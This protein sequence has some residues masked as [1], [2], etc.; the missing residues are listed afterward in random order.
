MVTLTLDIAVLWIAGASPEVNIFC[1]V[2]AGKLGLGK[3][4]LDNMGR[5]CWGSAPFC[6][7]PFRLIPIRLTWTKLLLTDVLNDPNPNPNPHPNPNPRIRRNG[8]RQNGIRRYG[9][10]LLGS[11]WWLLLY[12]VTPYFSEH[13]FI[14]DVTVFV[15]D[16]FI[17]WLSEQKLM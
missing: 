16:W 9:K 14:C 7:I 2:N 3:M 15:Y 13:W 10:T 17:D 1:V 6:L 12:I 4:G 5:H 8:I 11:W